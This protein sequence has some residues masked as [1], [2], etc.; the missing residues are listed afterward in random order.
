MARQ[1]GTV[2]DPTTSMPKK[3][4]QQQ[5][6][7]A[8]VASLQFYAP[9]HLEAPTPA[10]QEVPV[11]KE[12]PNASPDVPAAPIAP[13]AVSPSLEAMQSAFRLCTPRKGTPSS[14]DFDRSEGA[15]F[16]AVFSSDV[17]CGE[18]S[19]KGQDYMYLSALML[20]PITPGRATAPHEYQ[21]GSKKTKEALLAFNKGGQPLTAWADT[22]H[23]EMRFWACEK[24]G[25]NRGNRVEVGC[26]PCKRRFVCVAVY[27][28]SLHRIL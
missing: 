1:Q 13:V 6:H 4:Q 17:P 22:S 16:Y 27:L 7:Q 25:F 18:D 24:K 14:G 23:S 11:P 28:R 3:Q 21:R 10:V 2:F 19:F 8:P 5:Q 15:T 26:S 20:Q 12:E 9:E